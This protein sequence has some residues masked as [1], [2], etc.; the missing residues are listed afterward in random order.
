MLIKNLEPWA[1]E[2]FVFSPGDVI[3][4]PTNVGRDR[5]KAGVAA[6]HDGK[7]ETP[8]VLTL[9]PAKDAPKA[10]KAA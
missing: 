7:G 9:P 10:E 4:V 8:K 6:E 5:I 3:E 2:N 1:G